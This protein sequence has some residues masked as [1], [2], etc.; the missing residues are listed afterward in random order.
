VRATARVC[1][2][3][4]LLHG[5]GSDEHAAIVVADALAA[6]PGERFD[7]VLASP[8]FSKKSS[9]MILGEDGKTPTSVVVVSP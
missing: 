8:R 1:A 3:N 6:D 2:V 4:L 9:T 5:I 7:M